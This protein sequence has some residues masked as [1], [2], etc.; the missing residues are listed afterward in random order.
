[1]FYTEGNL[2]KIFNI[3]NVCDGLDRAI[4]TPPPPAPPPSHTVDIYE[5][6]FLV[7]I[8]VCTYPYLFIKEKIMLRSNWISS[9][10]LYDSMGIFLDDSSE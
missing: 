9:R 7:M 10:I 8:H 4:K 1:M 3:K 2:K 5:K 6:V